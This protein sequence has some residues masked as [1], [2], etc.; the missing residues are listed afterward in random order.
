[1]EDFRDRR[2]VGLKLSGIG[3]LRLSE[4]FLDF[5]VYCL[6]PL[7]LLITSSFAAAVAVMINTNTWTRS[8]QSCNSSCPI[9]ESWNCCPCFAQRKLKAW[10]SEPVQHQKTISMREMQ[11]VG[12]GAGSG[13][14]PV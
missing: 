5:F 9:V 8:V 11:E 14:S 7:G 2:A 12:D 6:L 1:M 4:P 10:V 3:R 13:S